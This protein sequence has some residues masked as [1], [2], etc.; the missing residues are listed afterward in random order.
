MHTRRLEPDQGFLLKAASVLFREAFQQCVQVVR[1]VS[2][3]ERRQFILSKL[4]AT[5]RRVALHAL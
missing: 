4:A 5:H 1:Y 2:N 3:R